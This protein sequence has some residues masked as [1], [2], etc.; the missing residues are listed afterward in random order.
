MNPKSIAELIHDRAFAEGA[1]LVVW[2][3]VARFRNIEVA[4]GQERIRPRMIHVRRQLGDADLD[5]VV[6]VPA[7]MCDVA[8][9]RFAASAELMNLIRRNADEVRDYMDLEVRSWRREVK[10]ENV[11]EANE[12]A[13][14]FGEVDAYAPKGK[15][16]DACDCHA[17]TRSPISADGAKIDVCSRRRILSVGLSM[18][19]GAAGALASVSCAGSEIRRADP[20]GV[21]VSGGFRACEGKPSRFS[22]E[23]Q[24]VGGRVSARALHS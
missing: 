20:V 2:L 13:G 17:V 15:G 12:A 3:D 11:E 6:Y 9:H 1:T 7:P 24:G 18:V 23:R 10:A 22:V 4:S 16:R 5:G 19:L 21:S 14:P 8:T